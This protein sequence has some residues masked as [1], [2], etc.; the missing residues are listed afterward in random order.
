[1]AR[2]VS[3]NRAICCLE[4]IYYLIKEMN[5]DDSEEEHKNQNNHEPG[6]PG[7][8]VTNMLWGRNNTRLNII[9]GRLDHQNGLHNPDDHAE[10]A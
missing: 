2:S 5:D 8:C 10:Q 9:S 4:R 3:T 6:P 1:M 7:Y